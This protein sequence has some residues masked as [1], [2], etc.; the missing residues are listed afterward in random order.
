MIQ[1]DSNQEYVEAEDLPT[2]VKLWREKKAA[3][4]GDDYDGDEEPDSVA[5]VHEEAVIR[6]MTD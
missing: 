6:A 5:L 4:W 2:A 1:F 3:D